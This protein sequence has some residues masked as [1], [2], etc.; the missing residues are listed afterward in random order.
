LL[1]IPLRLSSI[2][3]HQRKREIGTLKSLG[4]REI[5]IRDM[6]LVESSLIGIAGGLGGLIAAYSLAFIINIFSPVGVSISPI[7]VVGSIIFSAVVGIIAGTVPASDAAKLDP[8]EA[9]RS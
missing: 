2:Y 4:S 9:L 5:Q 1:P 8:V 7:V 6:F 3:F